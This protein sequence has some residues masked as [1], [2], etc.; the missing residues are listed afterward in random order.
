MPVSGFSLFSS[1]SP[2]SAR[3]FRP[4]LFASLYVGSSLRVKGTPRS[5]GDTLPSVF[6]WEG[7]DL[8]SI[9]ASDKQQVTT[10]D[11]LNCSQYVQELV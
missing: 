9:R 8:G 4:P 3:A 7:M 1:T 6:F 5:C 11:Q 10:E 2:R